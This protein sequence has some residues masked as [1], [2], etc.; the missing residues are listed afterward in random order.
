[1]RRSR[2]ARCRPP[3]TPTSHHSRRKGPTDGMPGRGRCKNGIPNPRIRDDDRRPILRRPL[4]RCRGPAIRCRRG[5]AARARVPCP[6][7]QRQ[8]FMVALRALPCVATA[9]PKTTA[10]S[11]RRGPPSLL[12][13]DG[14]NFFE[15]RTTFLTLK[16]F[17]RKT[18][19][20]IQTK[21]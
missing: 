8:Q 18:I 9:A 20:K 15:A 13:K 17:T 10:I 2:H 14:R 5:A 1:M 21:L 19:V 6:R 7:R 3:R 16:Y 11:S 12:P 4:R